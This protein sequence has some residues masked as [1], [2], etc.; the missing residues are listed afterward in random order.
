MVMVSELFVVLFFSSSPIPPQHNRALKEGVPSPTFIPWG[1]VDM[2][3][4]TIVLCHYAVLDT[5][6]PQ[7]VAH[8]ASLQAGHESTLPHVIHDAH[9]SFIP[10]PPAVLQRRHAHH[11]ENHATVFLIQVQA[12]TDIVALQ[13]Q[14]GVPMTHYLPHHTFLVT[15]PRTFTFFLIIHDCHHS[16]PPGPSH[17]SPDFF[18]TITRPCAFFSFSLSFFPASFFVRSFV[19]LFPLVRLPTSPPPHFLG[20][21]S[22]APIPE[23]GSLAASAAFAQRARA[24]PGVV[25]VGRHRPGY[26]LA[27]NLNVEELQLA[28]PAT[29]WLA[30]DVDERVAADGMLHMTAFPGVAV[31]MEVEAGQEELA[32]VAERM[33]AE[34][35]VALPTVPMFAAQATA[36]DR[37][38]FVVLAHDH[39]SAVARYLATFAAVSTVQYRHPVAL[40][41]KWA[42]GLDQSGVLANYAT[43][44][45]SNVLPFLTG[46]GEVI[47]CADSGIDTNNCFFYD[48]TYASTYGASAPFLSVP[49]GGTFHS[50]PC[51]IILIKAGRPS[52]ATTKTTKLRES[53][54]FWLSG[55]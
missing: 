47:G 21:C 7:A 23:T 54:Y 20:S 8:A 14:L 18:L 15:V 42:R 39:I 45:T 33:L 46:A 48:A 22:N 36:S 34:L 10:V 28:T 4:E 19:Q 9:P 11:V 32:A 13:G 27:G 16:F 35:Q 53:G 17:N 31:L 38:D 51:F 12:G 49:A 3:V 52:D 5:K 40:R 55:C 26:K 2:G 1:V 43:T 29:E 30:K 50:H 24:C 44:P 25:F 37:I 41:N 6:D